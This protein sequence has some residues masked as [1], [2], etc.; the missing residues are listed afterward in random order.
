MTIIYISSDANQ[1]NRHG[2]SSAQ[3]RRAH[4]P[5][6]SKRKNGPRPRPRVSAKIE[7]GE[8]QARGHLAQGFAMIAVDHGKVVLQRLVHD[9][10]K[11]VSGGAVEADD[12][13]GAG[14]GFRSTQYLGA[15]QYEQ[16]VVAGR[17]ESGNRDPT[18]PQREL[19]Q[20]RLAAVGM[21]RGPCLALRVAHGDRGQ[22]A[23]P[24]NSGVASLVHVDQ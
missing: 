24:E 19:V 1:I 5:E 4:Y 22:A 17:G 10:G 14:E 2:G 18:R 21:Y 12:A 11:N 6:G 23:M 13:G 20:Q 15:R 8:I 16:V 3:G 9:G 7:D